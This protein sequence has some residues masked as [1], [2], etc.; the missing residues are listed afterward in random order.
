ML[1][2]DY[3][4]TSTNKLLSIEDWS[5]IKK[6]SFPNVSNFLF[7]KENPRPEG[8][9]NRFNATN[10]EQLKTI[11]FKKGDKNWS[12]LNRKGVVKG[13]HERK[14]LRWTGGDW[15]KWDQNELTKTKN[16]IIKALISTDNNRSQA[17]EILNIARGTLYRLM[18]RCESIEWWNTEYPIPKR[19]PPRIPTEQRSAIQKKAIAKRM[20]GGEIV[21]ARSEEFEQKR[22][23]GLKKTQAKKREQR[24]K[25]L[26]LT[27]KEALEK[28]S[29]KRTLAAEILGIKYS[30]FKVWMSKT[31]HLVNWKEEYP[32]NNFK[33]EH[34]C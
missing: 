7:K 29:N 2:K 4:H 27:I 21:F 31:K 28:S 19:I 23:A 25:E 18:C 33:N 32:I 5:S 22:L 24:A 1:H 11:G 30:T 15:V 9:N 13:L 14:G 8:Y 6:S 12:A 3:R 16:K 26:V 10:Y 34:E 17:A 20:A